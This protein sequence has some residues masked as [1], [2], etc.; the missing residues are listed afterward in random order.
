MFGALG[1]LTSDLQHM[2]IRP[3]TLSDTTPLPKYPMG[4]MPGELFST[5]GT[6]RMYLT[7]A[8]GSERRRRRIS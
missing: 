1:Y 6:I 5:S 8:N 4:S 3:L 2:Q 7:S